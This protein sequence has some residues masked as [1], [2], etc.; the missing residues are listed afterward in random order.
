MEHPS[1]L[2]TQPTPTRKPPSVRVFQKDEYVDYTDKFKIKSF[3]DLLS[4]PCLEGY[5]VKKMDDAIVY[6][7]IEFRKDT[8]FPE[9]LEAIK[10][11]DQL[12]VEL[13]Y[14]GCPVPLPTWFVKGRDGKVNNLT[15]IENFPSHIR[16]ITNSGDE[17]GMS[18]FE[19]LEARRHYK[20]RGRPPYSGAVIRYALM[21]RHTSAQAYRLMLEKFP[22]P[23]FSLLARIQQ[24]GIDSIKAIKLLLEKGKI[25][26][27]VVLM[28]DEMYLDKGTQYHGG[29][30]IGDDCDGNLYKGIVG[31]MIVGLKKSIPYIVK[32]SPEVSITGSWLSKEIDDC[33]KLL[34]DAGFN[35]RAAVTDNHSTN[36][37]A[38][39]LLKKKYGTNDPDEQNSIQHP[40]NRSKT[41]LFF[42]NVHLLK[43]IRNNLLSARKFVFPSFHHEINEYGTINVPEGYLS[44]GDIHVV[45]EKD[46]KL[47]ANLRKAPKIG[48]KVLHPGSNK[49]SV[50]L[51]LAIFH[52]TTIVGI[53]HYLPERKDAAGF[54]ELINKW[55]TIVNSNQ[56]SSPNKL[57]DAIIEGDGK[58][59][60]LRAFAKYL[61]DW[62]A[63]S[64]HFCLTP[65]TSDA[66][67]RTLRAQADLAENL[68]SEGYDYVVP[69]RMQSDPLE[70]RYSRYRGM[71][72]GRFLVGL[73]EV[74]SA[75]RIIAIDSLLKEGINFWEEDILPSNADRDQ[76]F[77]DFKS[78]IDGCADEI[79]CVWLCDDSAEVASTISGY[80]AKR[81]SERSK[82]TEC[83]NLLLRN[84]DAQSNSYLDTLSRGGLIVPS[85]SL[86]DFTCNAFAVLEYADR[87]ITKYQSLSARR[88]GE[89][90][91]SKFGHH[92]FV[93]SE[94]TDWGSKFASRIIVNTFYNNKRKLATDSVK[95]SQLEPLKK[96][97]RVNP[98]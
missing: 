75:E 56:K 69:R 18:I 36:V 57:G 55:W 33:M 70:K 6:Y 73:R 47:K 30:Y 31:F 1:N 4:K 66:L 74:Q 11:D 37:N 63:S 59:E 22:L 96:R 15:Q 16:D 3:Q 51:A 29:D 67:I 58:P 80:V 32:A 52:D 60:F 61:E 84:R 49:Q 10:I 44:W 17:D 89:Y 50:P 87:I 12:R 64:S 28:A 42:D 94:H 46:Q 71:S 83:K 39:S 25:S 95:K 5:R 93:C 26:K 72:G 97:Q 98:K 7:H 13:Q 92:N 40:N 65:H 14:K 45:H 8:M 27:D 81:L 78:E 91:V 2:P 21:L 68:L 19:E 38:F 82:C 77:N 41:Y 9:L 53:K 54:L 88:G 24:G 48:Y 86:S 85:T 90:V 76:A 62:S 43:N 23:S 34:A 20:P 35:V 79:Q